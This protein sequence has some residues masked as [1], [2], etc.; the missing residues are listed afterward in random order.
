M[1]TSVTTRNEQSGQVSQFSPA[2]SQDGLTTSSELLSVQNLCV[3]ASLASLKT[4]RILHDVCIKVRRG[5]TIGIFGESGCGKTTLAR[6]LL[7]IMPPG[8]RITGGRVSFAANELVGANEG[9]LRSL[10]GNVI[11]V[12]HQ[13]AEGAL[14]PLMRV[15]E[16]ISEIF[17]AHRSWNRRQCRKEAQSVLAEVFAQDADRMGRSYPHELSGGQRQRVLIAQ[18][19]ACRPALVVA[20]EPTASLDLTT[21][22]EII[23]LIGDLKRRHAM[24]LVL[25]THNPRVLWELADQVIVM[26]AGRVVE[27]GPREQVFARP[28]H[29]YTQALLNLARREIPHISD[30]KPRLATIP[31]TAPDDAANIS[32]GCTYEPRCERRMPHCRAFE[33]GLVPVTASQQVRCLLYVE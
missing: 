33:P 30:V 13:E 16:Q 22:S 5:E 2:S 20:D 24:S 3:E 10:R 25:I 4:I 8:L 9:A 31:G 1:P 28:L 14:H 12:I 17:R 32:G 26:Y 18:A 29:P 23:S 7:G 11:S 15:R 19:I 27:H 6:A 21:Q